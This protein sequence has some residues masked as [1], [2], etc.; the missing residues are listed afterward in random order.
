MG[1]LEKDQLTKE[2]LDGFDNY[3]V[4]LNWRYLVSRQ[5][6]PNDLF[7]VLFFSCSTVQWIRVL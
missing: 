7:P 1:F 4:R 3:K 5:L 6:W 2:Q